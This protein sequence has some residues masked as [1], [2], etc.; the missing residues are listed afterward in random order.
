MCKW[1]V[2]LN[3][4]IHQGKIHNLGIGSLLINLCDI[5]PKLC[6]STMANKIEGNLLNIVIWPVY[7]TVPLLIKSNI[8]YLDVP[9]RMLQPRLTAVKSMSMNIVP[10]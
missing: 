6:S 5:K 1:E 8:Q 2:C 10:F 7:Y 9:N 3:D 4:T